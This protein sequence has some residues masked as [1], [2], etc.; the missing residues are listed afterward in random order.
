MDN[1][2]KLLKI[3]GVLFKILAGLSIAIGLVGAVGVL[4]NGGTPEVPRGIS[5]AIL[6]QAGI[7]FVIFY[8]VSEIIKILLVIEENTRKPASP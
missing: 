3:F 2:F 5:V 4:I 7:L 6:L 1:R 8:A